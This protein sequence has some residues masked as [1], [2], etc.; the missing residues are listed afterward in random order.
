MISRERWAELMKLL[1]IT[2]PSLDPIVVEDEFGH[3]A[4]I[5][6]PRLVWVAELYYEISASHYD[7]LMNQVFIAGA[8]CLE[9]SAIAEEPSV[10]VDDPESAFSVAHRCVISIPSHTRVDIVDEFP[11]DPPLPPV[12]IPE[13][14]DKVFAALKHLD[15]TELEDT[16]RTD[17]LDGRLMLFR[18]SLLTGIG[19]VELSV[20]TSEF[21]KHPT[22]E[23]LWRALRDTVDQLNEIY[24]HPVL[25]RYLSG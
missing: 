1:G 17:Q 23:A 8:R 24:D 22:L 7:V 5:L 16:W 11:F 10:S 12:I 25:R 4:Y 20:S 2:R 6:V 15:F 21:E 18:L 19:T 13:A 3:V 14:E 9:R